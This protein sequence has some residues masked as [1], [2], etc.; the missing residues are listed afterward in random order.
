[1]EELTIEARIENL[2]KVQ[3]FVQKQLEQYGCSKKV[4]QKIDVAVDE[5]FSNIAQYAYAPDTG[6]MAV[7][8]ELI[9]EKRAVCVTFVDKGKAYNPLQAPDPDIDLPLDLRPVGGLGIYLVRKL[10]DE[11]RYTRNGNENILQVVK[12]LEEKA[13]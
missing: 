7:G 6:S 3:E 8:V 1:M 4:L 13:S 5:I 2:G 12:N 11:I 10:M 9:Q